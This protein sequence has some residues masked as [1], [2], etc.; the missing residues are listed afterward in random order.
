MRSN[1]NGANQ[2][3]LDP[4]QKLCWENYVNPHSETFGNA[5]QSAIK[6]GYEEVTADR[7]TTFEWFAGKCRRLNMRIKA[8]EVLKEMM[9]MDDE[10]ELI[11]DG[12]PTGRKKRDPALTKIK[13]DTAKFAA[14]RLAKEDWSARQEVTGPDGAEL[15]PTDKTVEEKVNKA[16]ND[17]LTS[18]N[19]SGGN[20][21][22][23]ENPVPVQQG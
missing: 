2:Y 20:A 10:Q 17:Y 3:L 16:I 6:A 1:P 7:I 21:P 8:E 23:K 9:E 15:M 4:R 13:Q 22:G 5:K 11:I 19:S 12:M 18:I 14:E